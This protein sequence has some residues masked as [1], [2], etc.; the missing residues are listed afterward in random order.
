MLIGIEFK[1]KKI[2]IP[3][4]NRS[5]W[6]WRVAPYTKDV[7]YIKFYS[8]IIFTLGMLGV[9]YIGSCVTLAQQ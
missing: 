8:V 6:F 2:Y 1:R 4:E 9:L 5:V 7:D 3:E